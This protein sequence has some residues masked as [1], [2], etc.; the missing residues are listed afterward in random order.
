MLET[1]KVLRGGTPLEQLVNDLK[2]RCTHSPCR[3]LVTLNYDQIESPKRHPIVRECRGLVLEVGSWDVAARSFPRFFNAGEFPEEEAKF[4]WTD[5]V[6][7]EKADGSLMLL[8]HHDGIWRVNTRGSFALGEIQPGL[9]RTWEEAFYL[10]LPDEKALDLLPKGCTYVFEF[11]SRWNK[12]VRDYPDPTLFLLSAFWNSNGNE[13]SEVF[14]DI[15]AKRLGVKRPERY[16]LSSLAEVAK[17]VNDQEATFEGCVLRDRTGLRLKVKNKAYVAL[18]HLKD[19]GSVFATKRLVPLVLRNEHHEVL[20]AFP[21]AAPRLVEVATEMGA[22]LA[23]VQMAW[24]IA[25]QAKT[26]KEF[27][28][29]VN[30][31]GGPLKSILFTARKTGKTPWEVYQQSEELVVKTLEA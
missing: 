24:D 9:G 15:W 4:D 30:E 2:L 17:F 10:A 11:C 25:K 27:A 31:Y 8:Y 20:T 6:A 19:N 28:L 16:P 29:L 21:E 23:R 3:K 18:H 1:Q 14:C 26:Q 7:E 5:F 22:N 13:Q 12:V